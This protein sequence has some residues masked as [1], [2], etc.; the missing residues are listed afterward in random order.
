MASRGR[1]TTEAVLQE[2]GL[3]DDYDADEPMMPGS[4]DEFSDLED[5]YLE[6]VEDDDDSDTPP[7]PSDA[8]TPSSDTLPCWSAALNPV[9]IPPF[10]SPVGPKATARFIDLLYVCSP[11]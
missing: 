11:F 7:P 9:T 8:P 4:D 5:G 3:E 10:T 6:D 2:L 1:L